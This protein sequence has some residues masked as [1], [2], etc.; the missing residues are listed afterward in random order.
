LCSITP[1][2]SSCLNVMLSFTI[3]LLGVPGWD[4]VSL[5]RPGWP[6]TID[7]P[8]STS[9]VLGLLPGLLCSGLIATEYLFI[10]HLST[11]LSSS[12]FGNHYSILYSYEVDFFKKVPQRREIIRY[13][14]YCV[15]FHL[16]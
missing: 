16:I 15:L 3:F 14:S 13:L 6:Q 10:T 7:L 8:A 5:G 12:V 4:E 2:Y 11:L 1:K 9:R